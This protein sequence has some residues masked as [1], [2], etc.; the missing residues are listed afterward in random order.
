MSEQNEKQS[1]SESIKRIERGLEEVKN[2]INGIAVSVEQNED[3][4]HKVRGD[5]ESINLRLREI[6]DSQ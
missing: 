3:D 4:I 2:G 1:V 6:E 5:V